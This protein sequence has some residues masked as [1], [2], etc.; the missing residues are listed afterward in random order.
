MTAEAVRAYQEAKGMTVDGQISDDLL[1]WLGIEAVE[2][3][4]IGVKDRVRI[5]LQL[6][7]GL[8]QISNFYF[9]ITDDTQHHE[10]LGQNMT[11]DMIINQKIGN[12]DDD[13]ASKENKI[14]KLLKDTRDRILKVLSRTAFAADVTSQKSVLDYSNK[15][16]AIY[17]YEMAD[18]GFSDGDFSDQGNRLNYLICASDFLSRK[19]AEKNSSKIDMNKIEDEYIKNRNVSYSDLQKELEQKTGEK[20]EP[21]KLIFG[22][23][24][25][26][27]DYISSEYIYRNMKE[28]YEKMVA[29]MSK[30]HI[31]T[32]ITHDQLI[33]EDGAF[34]VD[35]YR[36]FYELMLEL[37]YFVK[38]HHDEMSPEEKEDLFLFITAIEDYPSYN[39]AR[40]S[41]S[42]YYH[43]VNWAK[44][45]NIPLSKVFVSYVPEDKDNKY[46]Y[47]EGE[48]QITT[49]LGDYQSVASLI[50]D[51]EK[52]VIDYCMD[53]FM[54]NDQDRRRDFTVYGN[55]RW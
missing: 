44:E 23:T 50:E 8:M 46:N 32:N 9:E 12:S 36:S 21:D 20:Y 10:V 24:I 39:R 27:E 25:R 29:L 34:D 6:E 28:P 2:D 1:V 41:T 19:E 54:V 47:W 22:N 33:F 14:I 52:A 45:R 31:N 15:L 16:K 53:I 37:Y 11:Y 38:N 42:I 13:T 17:G 26:M 43:M 51:D 48:E 3:E 4:N 35:Q 40:I 55:V 49:K 5:E 18:F 30:Y 7:E